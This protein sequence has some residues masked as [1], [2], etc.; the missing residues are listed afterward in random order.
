MKIIDVLR[1]RIVHARLYPAV[2][3]AVP[4]VAEYDG[5]EIGSKMLQLGYISKCSPE[6]MKTLFPD[7]QT[8]VVPAAKLPAD[9]Q[10]GAGKQ[11]RPVGAER[12]NSG[13]GRQIGI[14][15]PPLI[16]IVTASAGG[17]SRGWMRDAGRH[18]QYN[19]AAVHNQCVERSSILM[20][21][22]GF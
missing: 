2:P 8:R 6:V 21:S 18:E 20:C 11:L 14:V 10:S 17:D 5:V 1:D 16:S 4:V 22:T 9:T 12:V 3:D 19:N 13:P 15:P 7:L